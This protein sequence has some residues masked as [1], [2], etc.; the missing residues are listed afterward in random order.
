MVHCV[1]ALALHAGLASTGAGESFGM[2]KFERV[3][4]AELWSAG[5]GFSDH[6]LASLKDGARAL[7]KLDT[8]PSHVSVL[9]FASPFS[10]GL[11]LP[12]PCGDSA[13]L[14]WNRNVNATDFIAPERLFGGV[15]ILMVPKWG[16]NN[17]PLA[18]LYGD[19]VAEAFRPI[20]QTPFWTVHVRREQAAASGQ[21][22]PVHCE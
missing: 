22:Q 21:R 1:L 9:D 16:I 10:A 4:S 11:G 12:P 6:Y 8:P 18:D 15:R 20:S 2:P 13:W 7:S 17:V 5:G 14:H 3:R 19:Y